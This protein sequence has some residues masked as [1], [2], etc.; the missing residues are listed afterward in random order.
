MTSASVDAPPRC[1]TSHTR[2]RETA[3]KLTVE[4]IGTFFLVF[5][6][7]FAVAHGNP[8]APL[9]IG[10][11]LAVM[12]YAGG[13]I[14]GGH[15]NPA[16]TLGALVRGRIELPVAIGY[17]CAQV[18]AGVVAGVVARALLGA[19][20]A[21][22]H[23]TGHDLTAAL[24]VELLFTFALVYVV[25]NVATSKD[26]PQNS[27]YGLAIGGTVAAGALA[28]GPIS[29][30]VF[31]PAVLLGGMTMG[32]FGAITLLYLIVQIAGGVIAGLAF[33]YLNPGD[34]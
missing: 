17:W 30:G 21:S 6:V 29:G 34:K 11:V 9:A 14:S 25:L 3:R 23:P 27:F 4:A 18:I 33:R 20:P 15:Y 7:C 26:H 5:T 8:L 28:V 22:L 24:V 2:A 31:N 12:I 10:A 32:M 1:T 19:S 13:H 16:V